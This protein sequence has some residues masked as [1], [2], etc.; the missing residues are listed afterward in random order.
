M[1]SPIPAVRLH[2]LLNLLENLDVLD[3]MPFV[4]TPC[5]GLVFAT[6]CSDA[7]V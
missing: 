5:F 2:A 6:G 1:R 3:C 7:F 4:A